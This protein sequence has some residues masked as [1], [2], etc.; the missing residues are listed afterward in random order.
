M[1]SLSMHA[2]CSY[3]SYFFITFCFLYSL[4]LLCFLFLSLCF[5]LSL[6]YCSPFSPFSLCMSMAFYIACRDRICHFYPLTAFGLLWA[7]FQ[8]CP[9]VYWLPSYHHYTVLAVA[10]L[11]P[12]QMWFCFVSYPPRHSHQDKG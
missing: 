12:R 2:F 7:T 11:I 5:S 6:V 8:D 10:H 1:D 3:Q 9:P 4:S